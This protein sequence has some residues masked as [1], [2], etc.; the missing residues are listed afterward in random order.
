[1][2]DS[3]T[4]KIGKHNIEITNPD[5]LLYPDAKES[6]LDLVEY[7]RS[8]ANV[9]LPHL[10]NRPLTLRR[11]PDGVQED[12]FYQKKAADYFPDWIDRVQVPKK[13][14]G[15]QQQML[16]NNEASLIYL[17]NQAVLEFHT[18]LSEANDLETPDRMI[19]DLDPPEGNNFEAVRRGARCF[20]EF[21]K[22][23]NIT[24]FLQ[25]T[26]SKGVH[27]VIPLRPEEDVDTVREVARSLNDKLEQQ[28]P[29]VFTN[30]QRK[31]KRGGKLFLDIMR[32]AYGQH[33]VAPFSTR[34]RPGAPVATPITW[35]ELDD[36][37]IKSDT[38]NIHNIGRLL[39]KRQDPWQDMKRHRTAL[40]TLK[41]AIG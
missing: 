32:N 37:S 21:F 13:S 38:Y 4:I 41:K 8:I 15:G 12:G 23:N 20:H 28:F 10:E 16:C 25:L 14:G 40:N 29:D 39:S 26:G 27:V 7:Y 34:A 36:K 35:K 19:F 31:A 9:I 22:D 5:K 11:F 2:S 18:W 30:E 33:A 6:K 24:S 17:A 1:M 3:K